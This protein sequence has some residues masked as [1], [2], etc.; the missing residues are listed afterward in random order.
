MIHPY[1]VYS[2]THRTVKENCKIIQHVHLFSDSKR[3]HGIKLSQQLTEKEKRTHGVINVMSALHVL[4]IHVRSIFAQFDQQNHVSQS[5]QVNTHALRFSTKSKKGHIK[6]EEDA[7]SFSL[8]LSE[9]RMP[10]CTLKALGRPVV[11][12]QVEVVKSAFK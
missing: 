4:V 3:K 11:K 5:V 7:S 12:G 6:S 9:V 1:A 2:L 10:V 8:S